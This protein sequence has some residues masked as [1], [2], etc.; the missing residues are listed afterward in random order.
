MFTSTKKKRIVAEIRKRMTAFHRGKHIEAACLYWAGLACDEL[1]SRYRVRTILQ[2][3]TMEWPCSATDD[4]VAPTH[5]GYVWERDSLVTHSMI[6]Q[7][8]MPEIHVWA[9]IPTRN[10]IVDVTT[11]YLIRQAKHRACIEWTATA[12]PDFLWVRADQIPD[13]VIYQPDY[14]ATRLAVQ[15]LARSGGLR[16]S[17]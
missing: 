4:G 8:L 16:L 10:E 11:C 3:G 9:A 6:A 12:P 14:D 17:R 1:W 15:M 13:R 5:F 2:A 7:Q